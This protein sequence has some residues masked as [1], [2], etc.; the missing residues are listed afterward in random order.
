MNTQSTNIFEAPQGKTANEKIC[1]TFIEWYRSTPPSMRRY[2]LDTL[3]PV[4]LIRQIRDKMIAELRSG[5]IDRVVVDVTSP[6]RS[7]ANDQVGRSGR[8]FQ[9]DAVPPEV[10]TPVRRGD[11]E[12]E[13]EVST[14]IAMSLQQPLGPPSEAPAF[15]PL[16]RRDRRRKRGEDPSSGK[17]MED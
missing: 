17:G 6:M 16:D 5:M 9:S 12:E 3:G 14:A 15:I 11:A 8:F 10:A 13:Q 4:G 7:A 1:E 2:L